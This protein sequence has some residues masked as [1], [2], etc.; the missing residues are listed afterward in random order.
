MLVGASPHQSLWAMET[1]IRESVVCVC[2]CT[3][4]QAWPPRHT[5]HC[6]HSVH[7]VHV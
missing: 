3:L 7:R 4:R 5:P 6:T 1:H 2:V